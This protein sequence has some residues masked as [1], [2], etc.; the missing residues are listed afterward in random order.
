MSATYC[1][2]FHHIVELVGRRWTGVI[3]AALAST[4]MRFSRLREQIPGLS[5]RL[6]TER[7]AEL[8]A[9]GLVERTGAGTCV[10]FQLSE[11]G[12]G[13]RPVIAAFET[14]ARATAPEMHCG[15]RPGRRITAVG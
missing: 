13:L 2:Y 1:P 12:E 5:D 7:L 11:R 10:F 8:E 15:E 6:L 9:E 14:F 3:L 4:P